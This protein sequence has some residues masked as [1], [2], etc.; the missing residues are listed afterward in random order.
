MDG[1]SG[2][3]GLQR[4]AS[5]AYA[6][7]DTHWRGCP[8]LKS[9]RGRPIVPH[10]PSGLASR[11]APAAAA[12]IPLAG[13]R[14]PHQLLPGARQRR[15]EGQDPDP[16][17][18]RQGG[19]RQYHTAAPGAPARLAQQARDGAAWHCGRL[20]ARAERASS[21]CKQGVRAGRPAG[22]RCPP[23]VL[24]SP[25]PHAHLAPPGLPLWQLFTDLK[26]G[27]H[28][29]GLD[30]SAQVGG[31]RG[32]GGRRAGGRVHGPGAWEGRPA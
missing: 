2:S 25:P 17:P 8:H 19:S 15:E 12:A 1:W 5:Q 20:L 27:Y 14:A 23:R 11:P 6:Q 26:G 4:G 3:A 18:G 29:G 22:R 13:A 31:G 32:G 28:V 7:R 16:R 30:N 21:V 10:P 9:I 24:S